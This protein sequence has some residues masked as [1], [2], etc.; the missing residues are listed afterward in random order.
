[1]KTLHITLATVTTLALF[2]CGGGDNPSDTTSIPTT[3]DYFKIVPAVY[4]L[5][6]STPPSCPEAYR[7]VTLKAEK[8]DDI[9]IQTCDWTCASYEGASPIS[10]SLY[11][12][13]NGKDAPWE[14]DNAITLTAPSQ[15]YN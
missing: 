9:G 12:Q 2:G 15:C 1:M 8:E 13:Q 7:I 14:F 3:T 11:F 10:V 4:T 5:N 6:G